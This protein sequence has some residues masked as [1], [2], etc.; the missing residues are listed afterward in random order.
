[1]FLRRILKFLMSRVVIVAMLIALQFVLIAVSVELFSGYTAL[2]YTA[3]IIAGWIAVCRIVACGGNPSYKIAWVILVL[4][5]PPFGV[6]VYVI[7][8]GNKMSRRSMRSMIGMNRTIETECRRLSADP[9]HLFDDPTARRQSDYITASSLCPPYDCT[10]VRYYSTGEEFLPDMLESLRS[11]ERYIFLEY[12]IID[13]GEMWDDIHSIL[14]EKARAGVDVRII[15]DDMGCITH[16]DTGFNRFLESEGI[17]CRVFN[18]FI[19]V[20]SARLNN[21][22]HRKICAVDGVVAYTGG[23]NIADEYINR[24]H[25]YGY[26][27]DNAVRLKG[28]GA[29]GMTVMFLSMWDNLGDSGAPAPCDLA[30]YLPSADI[31]VKTCG[32]V[33]PYT[34]NP[35]DDKPVGET[36]YLNMIYSAREYV[37]ITTPYLVIDY[38]MEASLCTAAQS[39]IDVRIILPAV[40]DKR[41][42]NEVTKSNYSRLMESG[43]KLYEYSPGF[44]HQKTFLCD[45]KYATV[46]T[47][48]LDFRSL[49]LHFECGVWFYGGAVIG[50]IHRDFSEMFEVSHAVTPAD[51]RVSLPRRVMR[52]VLELM[53]PLF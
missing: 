19:P 27:K 45:G 46:G 18:R 7:F 26:W 38:G 51:C 13:R 43:V 6:A 2:F 22:N 41:L 47:V 32:A 17:L 9:D 3:A 12:F 21:R 48:N 1:M 39:G 14:I 10:D 49:Y 36:I 23:V 35:L 30:A 31:S 53:A 33:Q 15:Y 20:L 24:T 8:K 16:L 4:I 40:P 29:W 50:D 25:P 44:I 37:W 5:F 34:D 11:A 52:S 42:V 28:R